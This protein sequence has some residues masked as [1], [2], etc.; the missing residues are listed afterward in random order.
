MNSLRAPNLR[1][2]N[3]D[4]TTFRQADEEDQIE[5]LEKIPNSWLEQLYKGIVGVCYDNNF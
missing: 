5:N 2:K 3:H 1:P 4:N